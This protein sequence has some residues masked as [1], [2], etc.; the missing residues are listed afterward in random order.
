M[1][2]CAVGRR[3]VGEGVGLLEPPL[4]VVAPPRPP[5]LASSS[6]TVPCMHGPERVVALVVAVV[7]VVAVAV[8]VLG[9]ALALALVLLRVRPPVAPCVPSRWRP[10]QHLQR[11]VALP[12]LQVQVLELE[13][14]QVAPV[15]RV[16]ALVPQGSPRPPASRTRC[17]RHVVPPAGQ[18]AG[19]TAS[20]VWVLAVLVQGLVRVQLQ[21]EVL[22]QGTCAAYLPRPLPP[23][24]PRRRPPPRLW[25]L[26]S[27]GGMRRCLSQVRSWAE[28]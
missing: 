18:G 28:R 23:Q 26:L 6:L 13:L 3:G 9:L 12:H 25:I 17:S 8:L 5:R 22:L 7:A 19:G 20:R 15:L 21:V 11:P 27:P 1:R 24:Q 2:P 16:Q 14:A 10:W 4:P